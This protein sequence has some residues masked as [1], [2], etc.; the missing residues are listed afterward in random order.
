MNDRHNQASLVSVPSRGLMII[1]GTGKYL[2]V[3]FIHA[4]QPLKFLS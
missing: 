3:S 2:L 1:G 4:P